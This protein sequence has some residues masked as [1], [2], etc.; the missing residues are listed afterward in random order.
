MITNGLSRKLIAGLYGGLSGVGGGTFGP[1][2]VS[3]TIQVGGTSAAF[4]FNRP[5]TRTG[6]T[7]DIAFD[8]SAGEFKGDTEVSNVGNTITISLDTTV[9]PG[10]TAITVEVPL[11][12]FTDANGNVLPEV[13]N[14]A[15][16][17]LSDMPS[18]DFSVA[19]NSMYV[20]AIL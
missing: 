14:F 16:F 12:V 15:C 17:F 20:G 2:L 13:T 8:S 7:S 3:V 1:R 5:M 19:S 9:A 11:G 10:T 18:L 6:N 4:V